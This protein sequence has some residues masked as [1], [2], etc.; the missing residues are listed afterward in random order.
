MFGENQGFSES[1]TGVGFLKVAIFVKNRQKS[2]ISGV[3]Q[4][5]LEF[6]KG[7]VLSDRRKGFWGV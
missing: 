6:W 4:A 5:T 7:S 3:R 2:S 1:S